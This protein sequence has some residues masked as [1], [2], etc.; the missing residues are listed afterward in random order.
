LV[1]FSLF[2]SRSFTWGTLL[3]TGVTFSMF[4]LLFGLP[5]FFQAVKG[6]DAFETGLRLLPLIGGTL[7]GAKISELCIP[8]FG[9][10]AVI[11]AGFVF[12]ASG[13][14]L[15][16]GTGLDTGL[17]FIALW[18]VIAGVGLGFALPTSMDM[19]M[20]ELAEAKSGIG[21]ALIMATRQVGAS[22]SVALLGSALNA[23]Y[24]THLVLDGA[25]EA[26]VQAVRK[27]AAAGTAA[28][29]KLGSQEMLAMIRSAYIH[30]MELLLWICA[31][32]ALA[33]LLLG[34]FFLPGK[35]LAAPS[36]TAGYS[37]TNDSIAP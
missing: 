16:T 9:G 31:G 11:S 35:L 19:A 20:G 37:Q 14:A 3:A 26:A 30:G 32:S 13:L 12:L 2:R 33:C 18:T 25:P 10:K 1:D 21:S 7:A 22:I 17:G 29:G 36:G 4:G 28:A 15:G 6:T 34:F 8:R 23:A 24:R 27:S 5:Q